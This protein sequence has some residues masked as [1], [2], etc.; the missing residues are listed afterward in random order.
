MKTLIIYYSYGGNTK[1]IAEEIQKNIGGDLAEIKTAQPYTGSY[2]EVVDLGQQ[3]VESGFE[4][5]IIFPDTDFSQYDKI[6]IGTPVWWYTYAPAVKSFLSQTD[7][8]GKDVFTFATNGG[9]LG[10]TLGDFKQNCKNAN[11][12]DGVGIKFDGHTLVT[13]KSN[14]ADFCKKIK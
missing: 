9:W 6:I 11:V 4:P 5:E 2:N 12:M 14:I 13:S 8:K 1:M 10:H 3:Q 7:F